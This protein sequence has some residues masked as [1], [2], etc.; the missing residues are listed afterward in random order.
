MTIY[1]IFL[2]ILIFSIII[3]SVQMKFVQRKELYELDQL[4]ED[5]A[6]E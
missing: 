3:T 1:L 6:S 5:I 2:G 4:F